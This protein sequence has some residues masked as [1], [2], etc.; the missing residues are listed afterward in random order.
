MSRQHEFGLD[1][2][3][4]VGASRYRGHLTIL[5]EVLHKPVCPIA[6]REIIPAIV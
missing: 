3:A 1:I 4:L 5:S 2:I 6:L